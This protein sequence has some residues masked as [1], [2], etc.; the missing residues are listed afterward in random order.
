MI[1]GMENHLESDLP[2]ETLDEKLGPRASGRDGAGQ[3][4]GPRRTK[5]K[6]QPLVPAP[7][8]PEMPYW[9]PRGT[10]WENM[11]AGVKQAVTQVLKPAYRRL[12]LDAPSDLE[13]SV[14]LTLVHLMWLE[15]FNPVQLAEAT[16]DPH[17]LAAIQSSPERMTD[18][19]M[20]LATA[21]CQ[22][23]EALVKLRMVADA[24]AARSSVV[25]LP[26]PE[27]P[28]DPMPAPPA[29]P[30]ASSDPDPVIQE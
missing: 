20:Q 6:P 14:G 3:S 30:V 25:V 9:V 2:G 27:A 4:T 15:V 10:V 23:A 5:R 18:R 22:A 1:G 21:K 24:L 16:A 19:Y 26:P 13:R 12:V 8:D 17:S 11:P 28:C 29:I 7:V